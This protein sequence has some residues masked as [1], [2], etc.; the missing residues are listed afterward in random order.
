MNPPAR[1]KTVRSVAAL[2]LLAAL[3]AA[4]GSGSAPPSST[5][6]SSTLGVTATS[7]TAAPGDTKASATTAST[8]APSA[9]DDLAPF[10]AE[11]SRADTRIRAAAVLVNADL[12]SGPTIQYR[13]TTVAAIQAARPVAAATAIPTGLPPELLR[14]TLLT[15]SDLTARANA[16]DQVSSERTFVLGC[17]GHGR[18]PAARFASDL[19]ATRI[20][21]AASPRIHR[22]A[23]DSR[24]AAELA[25]RIEQ[26]DHM[27]ACSGTCGGMIRTQLATVTWHRTAPVAPGSIT[28]DGTIDGIAFA[29]RYQAGKGWD[30]A[31]NA[32]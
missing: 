30:V 18:A 11:A 13:S 8:S 26:I 1:I 3:A 23:P 22:A 32:C 17:L 7:A 6:G 12:G 24:A 19:A 14:Q 9:A 4:C 29:V 5:P 20:S 2:L 15:Y 25:L 10:L 27:N 28:P 31:I 21:A 16:F